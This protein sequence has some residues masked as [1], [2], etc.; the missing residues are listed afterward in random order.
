M[1]L[2]TFAGTKVTRVRADARIKSGHREA[3]HYH[4]PCRITTNNLIRWNRELSLE[5]VLLNDIHPQGGLPQAHQT[6]NKSPN[7]RIS[8]N[9]LAYR[10][11]I[12]RESQGF[13]CVQ[14]AGC[15]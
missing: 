14:P 15:A 2:V 13:S 5:I 6:R 1:V 3:I 11:P 10:Q 9:Q 12:T 8:L 7:P 4:P